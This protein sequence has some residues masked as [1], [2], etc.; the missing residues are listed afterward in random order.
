MHRIRL[1]V[2]AASAMVMLMM[3]PSASAALSLDGTFDRTVLKPD[4]TGSTCAPGV[5]GN[6]CG[7]L[8][9]IGLGPADYVYRY[10]SMFEPNGTRGCFAIDGTFTIRMQSDG[11]TISGPL[12]G[13]FCSLSGRRTPQAYG[14]PFSEDDAVNFAS[15]T[16]QFAG[17]RGTAN[18]Q[19][20]AAGA[21]NRGRLTGTLSD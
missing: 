14:N 11:S 15:G 18:F 4:F 12:S 19:Q 21:R 13:V 2:V 3:A 9:F 1:I 20:S 16:G 7:V 10:G 6:E 17:L 8:Q 5:D